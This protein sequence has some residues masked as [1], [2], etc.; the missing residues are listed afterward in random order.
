MP[1]RIEL[2]YFP[3][4]LF[5]ISLSIE[6]KRR[7]IFV[8][9]DGVVGDF[10]FLEM[11]TLDCVEGTDTPRFS[12]QI[13]IKAATDKVLDEYK[14]I[15]VKHGFHRNSPPRMEAVTEA[16]RLYYPHWVAYYRK[17]RGYDFKA[18]DGVSLAPIGIRMRRAFLAVFSQ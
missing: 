12:F 2:V 5:K 13:D 7:E 4:Y 15:L 11:E 14:W 9:C 3:Y 8:A 10:A 17:W 6:G 1:E 18:V 16:Q